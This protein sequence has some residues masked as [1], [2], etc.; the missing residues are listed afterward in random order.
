MLIGVLFAASQKSVQTLSNV[1]NATE[2]SR[3][4][5]QKEKPEPPK[6]ESNNDEVQHTPVKDLKPWRSNMKPK[7]ETAQEQSTL[8]SQDNTNTKETPKP[9]RQNMKKSISTETKKSE[10]FFNFDYYKAYSHYN[11]M[12][13]MLHK[14]PLFR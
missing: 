10:A 13:K 7:T 12:L 6:V 9:W 2:L 3:S 14:K 4:E 11:F 1:S 5:N 8:N